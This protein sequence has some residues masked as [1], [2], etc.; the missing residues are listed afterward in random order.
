M[1][2]KSISIALAFV[3]MLGVSALPA[4]AAASISLDKTNYVHG[5]TITVNYSG[6]TAAMKSAQAW[7]GI[8]PQGAAAS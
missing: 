1:I 7:I 4:F 8:A 3:V 2:K 6:V 5:E